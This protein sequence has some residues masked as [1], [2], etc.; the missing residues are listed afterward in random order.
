ML[1]FKHGKAFGGY[2]EPGGKAAEIKY[3]S[4]KSLK[5]KIQWNFFL[6]DKLHDKQRG[7]Y[8]GGKTIDGLNYR[9]VRV[10]L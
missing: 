9:T 4:L 8:T 10:A 6:Y 7:H 1:E 3:Y 5:K 2:K